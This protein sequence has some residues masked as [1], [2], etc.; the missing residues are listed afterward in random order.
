MGN[1]IA[2]AGDIVDECQLAGDVKQ[3]VKEGYIKEVE[4]V[5]NED[6]DL[7]KLKKDELVAYAKENNF[8]IDESATKATIIAAIL[9]QAQE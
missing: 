1:K 9:E 2:H 7:S 6:F 4:S 8:E 5:D 3:L